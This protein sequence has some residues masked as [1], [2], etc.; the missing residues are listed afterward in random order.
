M[1]LT[2][3]KDFNTTDPGRVAQVVVWGVRGSDGESYCM[4]VD[5][6][7]GAFP[8]EIVVGGS[9]LATE[10]TLAAIES[11]VDGLETL[12]GTTNSELSTANGKLDTVIGHVDGIETLIG[13]TNST[14]STI[15]GNVDGLETAVAATNTRLGE[16]SAGLVTAKHDSIVPTFNATSDVWE[17]KL[18]GVTQQTVTINYTDATKAVITS[19]VRT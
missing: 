12:V 10:A 2:K 14:L 6:T 3:V 18:S 5:Q 4:E 7:T 16:M 15:S 1:A 11:E 9:A 13:T 8:V 19:V 17:F